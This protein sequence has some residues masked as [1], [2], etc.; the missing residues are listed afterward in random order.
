MEE[1]DNHQEGGAGLIL[2]SA[3][4]FGFGLLMLSLGLAVWVTGLLLRLVVLIISGDVA[5]C[6]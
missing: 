1:L 4:L 6:H 5:A 3:G 2:V